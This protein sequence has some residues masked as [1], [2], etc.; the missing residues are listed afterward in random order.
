[1][2]IAIIAIIATIATIAG[3]VATTDIEEFV[4]NNDLI[5]DRQLGSWSSMELVSH[6]HLPYV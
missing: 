4:A 1:M 2:V 5:P 3:I 6:I